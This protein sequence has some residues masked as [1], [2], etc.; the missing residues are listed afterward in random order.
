VNAKLLAGIFGNFWALGQ[1]M[2][3]VATLPSKGL[4]ASAL[5]WLA[6]IGFRF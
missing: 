1:Q 6:Y 4:G 2:C 3:F 5:G